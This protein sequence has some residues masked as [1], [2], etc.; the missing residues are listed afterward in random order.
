MWFY[1]K[2]T[3]TAQ[4]MAS[5]KSPYEWLSDQTKV[6]ESCSYWKMILDFQMKFHVFVRSIR[7]ENFDLNT[8]SLRALIIWC[9]I[10]DKYYYARW[11]TVHIFELITMHV[12]HPEV[13]KNL[14]KGFFSFQKSNKEFS[15]MAL[16]QVHEQSNKVIKSTGGT[17]DLVNIHD[18]SL[19]RWETC[20]HEIARIITEF[21]E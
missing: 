19:I 9:F 12:K 16:D 17:T 10:M 21:E 1:P 4:A 2:L 8:E 5:T 20:G 7:E 3:E 6:S 11:L 14:E 18:S 15:R 13:Y